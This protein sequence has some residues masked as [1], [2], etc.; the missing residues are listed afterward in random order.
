[1]EAPPNAAVALRRHSSIRR[2]TRPLVFSP[3]LLLAFG[4]P[5]DVAVT[6]PIAR[7]KG[8][9]GYLEC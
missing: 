2:Q 7:S 8:S 4:H 9:T 6:P 3:A 1:M 5:T